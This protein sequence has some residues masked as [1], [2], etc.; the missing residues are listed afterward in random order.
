MAKDR[1]K[2]D[3]KYYKEHKLFYALIIIGDFLV[4]AVPIVGYLWLFAK[5]TGNVSGQPLISGP[6]QG[7]LLLVGLFGS[8]GVILGLA[9]IWMS[10]I[11]QYLGHKKT[12][13]ALLG[14]GLT[15]GLTLLLLSM[16]QVTI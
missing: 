5:V 14:G 10:I 13:S 4:V 6:I 9:S 12:F 8:V 3:A 1:K 7:L 11:G 16:L 15:C 2:Y